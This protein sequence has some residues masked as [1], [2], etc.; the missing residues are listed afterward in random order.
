[1]TPKEAL[2]KIW[3]DAYPKACE[4]WSANKLLEHWCIVDQALIELEE[5]KRDVARYFELWLKWSKFEDLSDSEKWELGV[6][7]GKLLKVG[8]EE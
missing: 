2:Q 1:M 8:K 4:T 6:L 7:K 5:L 3:K